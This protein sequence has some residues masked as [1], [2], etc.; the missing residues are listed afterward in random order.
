MIKFFTLLAFLAQ[1]PLHAK[2]T[3][4]DKSKLE[5][6][7][8]YIKKNRG[9]F[10]YPE[11]DESL[12][13]RSLDRALLEKKKLAQNLARIKAAIIN[14]DYDLAKI[15]LLRSRYNKDF[16]LPIQFRYLAMMEFIEGNY[17]K[18]LQA[19]KQGKLTKAQHL[20]HIC[21]LQTLN[22]VIIGN[23]SEASESWSECRSYIGQD[24]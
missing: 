14:G 15:L 13:E 17:S 23:G 8:S 2:E 1:V 16:T 11:S 21:L 7:P 12:V 5:L 9:V 22:H 3:N 24:T 4:A 10:E 18:S 19:I 20:A 6:M